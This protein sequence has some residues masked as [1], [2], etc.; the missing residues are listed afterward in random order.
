MSGFA[1]GLT[2]GMALILLMTFWPLRSGAQPNE[3]GQDTDFSYEV[4]P[5]LHD[6]RIRVDLV[7]TTGWHLNSRRTTIAIDTD[8]AGVESIGLPVYASFRTLTT[9]TRVKAKVKRVVHGGGANCSEVLVEFYYGNRSQTLGE[10]SYLHVLPEVE[11]GEEIPL[12]SGAGM[13]IGSLAASPWLSLS[14]PDANAIVALAGDVGSGRIKGPYDLVFEGS[15]I[16]IIR[17][18]G[19]WYR[20]GELS[21]ASDGSRCASTGA[22]LHQAV[23]VSGTDQVWRNLDRRDRLDDDGLGFPGGNPGTA[24]CS[25]T[26]VYRLQSSGSAPD[27]SPVEPCAAPRSAPSNLRASPQNG[28]LVLDWADPSDATITGYRYRVRLSGATNPDSAPWGEGWTAVPGSGALT[29]SFPLDGLTNGTAYTVQLRADERHRR[30][31]DQHHHRDPGRSTAPPTLGEV[32]ISG[33][34]L[35]ASFEWGGAA[36][37]SVWWELHRS[38]GQ[39][40]GFARVQGPSADSKC[41]GDVRE[42][43]PGLLVP[44][45]RTNLRVAVELARIAER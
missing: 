6:G 16:S 10:V 18:E 26:W 24:F 17:I 27:A 9:D 1:R 13:R 38:T 11:E 37:R 36:P 28:R 14:G 5:G 45:S 25:D 15:P 40:S 30:G 19:R 44:A 42:P 35:T 22:H 32:S 21:D 12:V 3:D 8:I 23:S 39:T 29:T 20:L 2:A 33:T 7:L 34:T 43:G 41:S 4:L 31:S